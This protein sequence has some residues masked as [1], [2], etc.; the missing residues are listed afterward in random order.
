MRKGRRIHLRTSLP[1]QQDKPTIILSETVL[2]R[3]SASF[4]LHT[5][6]PIS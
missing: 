5:R 6:R 3:D 1:N 4:A 2:E